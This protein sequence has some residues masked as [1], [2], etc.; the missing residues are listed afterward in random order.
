MFLNVLF[1]AAFRK[2]SH[3]GNDL[4]L[5]GS[6]PNVIICHYVGIFN[7]MGHV[8]CSSSN[9]STLFAGVKVLQ[10]SLCKDEILIN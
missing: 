10:T 4:P 2:S 1:D 3:T 6:N 5:T 8:A 7:N 9:Y